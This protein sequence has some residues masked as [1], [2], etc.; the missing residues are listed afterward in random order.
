MEDKGKAMKLKSV[1]GQCSK[2]ISTD[3]AT[4]QA[5]LSVVTG[6]EVTEIFSSHMFQIQY[7]MKT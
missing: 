5:N 2:D 3:N 7:M 1:V 6:D 4:T